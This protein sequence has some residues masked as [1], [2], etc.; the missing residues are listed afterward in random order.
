MAVDDIAAPNRG[1]PA[2]AS[3]LALAGDSHRHIAGNMSA[4]D[5]VTAAVSTLPPLLWHMPVVLPVRVGTLISPRPPPHLSRCF[6]TAS[7]NHSPPALRVS[8]KVVLNNRLYSHSC[9]HCSRRLR[10]G[11]GGVELRSFATPVSY[12]VPGIV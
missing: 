8:M 7:P 9:P 10:F 4:V 1:Y 12:L 5:D 6:C 3:P 11:H 2:R